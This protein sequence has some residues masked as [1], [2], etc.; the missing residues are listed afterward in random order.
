[1]AEA[2]NGLIPT[3]LTELPPSV[4]MVLLNAIYFRGGSLLPGCGGKPPW[5]VWVSSK[6][7]WKT[8]SSQGER[9]SLGE[10]KV[11]GLLP[12]GLISCLLW[13]RVL[14]DQVR[15]TTDATQPVLPG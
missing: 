7:D 11:A 10:G 8:F 12:L 2:T 15:P 3:M 9:T 4:V 5:A 14:E 6:R 13:P 1:M